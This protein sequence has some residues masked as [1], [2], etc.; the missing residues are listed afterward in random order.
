MKW[1]GGEEL[2]IRENDN[3]AVYYDGWASKVEYNKKAASNLLAK[4]LK[5]M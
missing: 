1:G 3:T 5:F 2:F 4:Y